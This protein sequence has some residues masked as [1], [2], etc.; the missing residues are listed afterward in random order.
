MIEP[1]IYTIDNGQSYRIEFNK[2]KDSIKF[3]HYKTIKFL[4]YDDLISLRESIDKIIIR[5][6]K[7]I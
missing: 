2:T 4:S 7:D 6:R 1:T 5:Y 3:E